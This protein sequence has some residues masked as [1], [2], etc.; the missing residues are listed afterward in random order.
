MK[1]NGTTETSLYTKEFVM[2][3]ISTIIS[4][5]STKGKPSIYILGMMQVR[6]ILDKVLTD[7]PYEMR[8]STAQKYFEEEDNADE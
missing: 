1:D 8:Y 7:N 6:L 4:H 5:N 3:Q 2:K